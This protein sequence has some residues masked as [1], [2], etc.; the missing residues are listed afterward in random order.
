MADNETLIEFPCD[1]PI[2][3]M[4]EAREGFAEIITATIQ[5]HLP[6]FHAGRMSVRASRGGRYLSLTCSVYVTSK[7]ELDDIYRTLTAHPMVLVVL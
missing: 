1:F 4:G 6:D 3:V 7:P 2:K 5:H